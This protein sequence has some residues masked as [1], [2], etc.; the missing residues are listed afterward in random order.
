MNRDRLENLQIE[1]LRQEAQAFRLA[2]T[3]NRSDLSDRI[4]SHF[5][6]HAS[7]NLNGVNEAEG[8]RF[9]EQQIMRLQM[10][11]NSR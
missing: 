10:A 8:E 11:K 1:E 2:T 6:R 3:D 9:R 4:M 7:R 5:E